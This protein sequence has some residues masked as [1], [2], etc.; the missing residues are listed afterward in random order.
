[1]LLIVSWTSYFKVGRGYVGENKARLWGEKRGAQVCQRP[2]HETACYGNQEAALSC[3]LVS[4][5]GVS[6]T[7]DRGALPFQHGGH[8]IQGPLRLRDTT[9]AP[10]LKAPSLVGG[11][12]QGSPHPGHL[13]F[14]ALLG[15]GDFLGWFLR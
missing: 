13:L 11:L 15:E 12:G 8:S 1:M 10:A 2:P 3:L 5:S 4:T 9:P 14:K 6:R 7:R